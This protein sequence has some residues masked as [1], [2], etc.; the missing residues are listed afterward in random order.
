M[1]IAFQQSAMPP[2]AHPGCNINLVALL[3]GAGVLPQQI[4]TQQQL[5]SNPNLCLHL[6]GEEPGI[7]LLVHNRVFRLLQGLPVKDVHHGG[8]GI[9]L[10]LL[11]CVK[12]NLH[13]LSPRPFRSSGI[14]LRLWPS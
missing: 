7:P 11:L 3:D 8:H 4:V 6:P 14:W 5:I 1:G 9:E 13:C 10:V 2:A 12:L